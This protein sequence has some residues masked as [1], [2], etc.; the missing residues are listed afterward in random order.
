M[1]LELQK[2]GLILQMLCLE[3]A[4]SSNVCCAML[5][6]SVAPHLLGGDLC[7]KPCCVKG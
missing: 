3:Q 4:A 7:N 1:R 2:N 6:P 5:L